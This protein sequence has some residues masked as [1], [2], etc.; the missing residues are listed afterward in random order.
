[1]PKIKISDII[2]VVMVVVYFAFRP[3]GGGISLTDMIVLGSIVLM[4]ISKV[5][6]RRRF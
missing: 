4:I 3:A 6:G 1:M 5:A 2:F